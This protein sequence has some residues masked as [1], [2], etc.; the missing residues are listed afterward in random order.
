MRSPGAPL[1]F[2]RMHMTPANL[3][4]HC[5]IMLGR[6]YG[7][8]RNRGASAY[9][10]RLF[11]FDA[12]ACDVHR[13]RARSTRRLESHILEVNVGRL[14]AVDESGPRPVQLIGPRASGGPSSATD[15]LKIEVD[16]RVRE[17]EGDAELDCPEL[18]PIVGRTSVVV[19]PFELVLS[20]TMVRLLMKLKVRLPPS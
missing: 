16:T 20:P 12:S 13:F 11:F 2:S 15:M 10:H 19:Q 1:L 18:P 3:P 14:R 6:R 7:G 5:G 9:P 4:S 8:S 17:E